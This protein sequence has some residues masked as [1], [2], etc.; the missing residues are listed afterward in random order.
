MII[1]HQREK[2]INAM[3][4][5][6]DHTKYCGK[7]K[8]LKLMY[9]LDF[10]HFKQTGKSVTGL[11][12][13]A[14]KM[15]PVPKELYEE[16]SSNASLDLKSAINI[17]SYDDFRKIEPRRKFNKECFTKR[18]LRLLEDLSFIFRDAQVQEMIEVTHLQNKPWDRTLKEKGPFSKIDYLLSIDSLP[19]SLPY[20]VARERAQEISEM[21]EL[22]GAA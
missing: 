3:I 20:D 17:A 9:F 1:T 14:W 7:T 6:A 18:E 16:L 2:L 15:G 22:F 13:F 4:F 10:C 8:I 19:D 21:H 11:E 5:F 12:Y